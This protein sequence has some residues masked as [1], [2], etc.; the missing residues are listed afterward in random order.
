M[1]DRHDQD[2]K[3]VDTGIADS[4][5]QRVTEDPDRQG[6]LRH[7]SL[8]SED[9]L[10]LHE[11]E[12]DTP[13]Q[14][15]Q[16]FGPDTTG[17]ASGGS[18][19]PGSLAWKRQRRRRLPL[20]LFIATCLSTFWVGANHW[21]PWPV[22]G[23]LRRMLLAHWQDGL[24]YMG[25]VLAILFAHEM[26]HFLAT[27]RY[28]IPASFPYF[29]PFPISPIGT[30]GAV[31]GMDG[32]KAD[33]KELF[34]IGLAGPLSGLVVALPIMCIGVSKLDFQQFEHGPFALDFPLLIRAAVYLIQP[35]G[36]TSESAV[37]YSHLNP[38]FMA[39]W[40]GLLITGLNM[41]PVS[42]LDGG[43]VIYTLFGR[44]AHWIA[45]TFVVT[46]ILMVVVSGRWEWSAMILIVLL[47]GPD[48]PPTRNDNMPLGR[49][50]T[51]LG[52]S[53]ILIPVFCFPL[54][55]II[56]PM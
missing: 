9:E 34:D 7:K 16:T 21:L 52:I 46:A 13:P 30:M 41:M 2:S 18:E 35:A 47:I 27:V 37:W 42:Q 15:D 39:G 56:L 38:Y 48:H 17:T 33:R 31:I 8:N 10:V 11:A 53:A 29:I 19:R 14:A 24:T 43:H 25:C 4:F 55:L 20:M 28:G 40:V 22:D 32:L 26:G 12:P 3:P 1:S 44:K 36:Y 54:R 51:I 6:A 23:E 45:R 50:R 49:V 5:F